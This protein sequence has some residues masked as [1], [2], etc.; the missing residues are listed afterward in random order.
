MAAKIS[1]PL[2]PSL[3]AA[4]EAATGKS[5]SKI[6]SEA[7]GGG[8]T[9]AAKN[10]GYTPNP[11]NK[12]GSRITVV[13]GETFHSSGEAQRWMD[14]RQLQSVGHIRKLRRQVRFP[15]IVNGVTLGAYIADFVYEEKQIHPRQPSL[16]P[17]APFTEWPEIVEDFKGFRTDMYIWKAKHIKAQYGVTIRETSGKTNKSLRRF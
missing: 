11:R 2:S 9:A 3:Q 13:D 1:G 12:Y 6:A 8:K 14:L 16:I 4:I 7:R 17:V 5:A 10:Y 15:L